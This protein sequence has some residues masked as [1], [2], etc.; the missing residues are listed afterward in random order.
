MTG[1]I[2]MHSTILD[3]IVG[4]LSNLMIKIYVPCK[5]VV[6]PHPPPP[7]PALRTCLAQH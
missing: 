4:T 6:H 3:K 5:N 1:P 7:P 2:C